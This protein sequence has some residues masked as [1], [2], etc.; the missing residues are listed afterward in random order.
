MM[1]LGLVTDSTSDLPED[2]IE[3]LGVEVIPTIL[4]IEGKEY[5]DGKGISREAFYAQLP[6]M[7]HPPSTAAPSLGE[8]FT[9]YKNLL[10]HGCDHI[11]SIHTAEQLTTTVN[12]ARQAAAE[13]PGHVTV[14][15]SGSLS[16]GVGFQLLAAAEAAEK[17]LQAA[18][19]AVRSVK[20]RVRVYAALDTMENLRR[21]GR[22]PAAVAALGGLLSI[23][24]VIE[25]AD[26]VVK[27]LGA[28]RTTEQANER[29]AGLMR[30]CGVMERLA[31]LHTGAEARA[32]S[33]LQ[34]MMG[35][36]SQTLL[37]DVLVLN[38]TPVIGAH[39]GANGLGFAAVLASAAG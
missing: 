28:V 29:L 17:G 21:S 22:V 10:E 26:G 5:A 20:E 39:L 1:K 4:I 8:F 31:I 7:K 32:R 33:F 9:R 11:L 3:R 38:V 16:L 2:L 27:A 37:R 23:K 36:I 25:L 13:F 15:D 14:I 12:I 24:P 6:H 18:L 19:N 30:S 35:E 34:R